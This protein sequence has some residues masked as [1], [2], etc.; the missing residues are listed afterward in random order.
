M[1]ALNTQRRTA[2]VSAVFLCPWHGFLWAAVQDALGR[3]GF[4]CG[5]S[6][7]L[8]GL[9]TLLVEGERRSTLH[10]GNTMS[11]SQSISA[12]ALTKPYFDAAF[13]LEQ[14]ESIESNY[15]ARWRFKRRLMMAILSRS[16]QEL[17][18]GF[19][20]L[21]KNNGE[22]YFEVIDQLED[23]LDHLKSAV[24]L[25]ESSLYR[26]VFVGEYLT[27]ETGNITG[28]TGVRKGEEV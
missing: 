4:L 16:S 28:E 1:V 11:E 9:P 27:Q 14:V 20:E 13:T 6:T 7:N 3:A 21:A 10:K 19:P 22:A 18:D 12:D 23:Y 24:Q 5:R 17:L 8:R 26:L 2:A 15:N 25:A